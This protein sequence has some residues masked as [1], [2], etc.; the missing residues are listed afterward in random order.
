MTAQ[1]LV[2][3]L[4]AAG[5]AH[6]KVVTWSRPPPTFGHGPSGATAV[7]AVLTIGQVTGTVPYEPVIAMRYVRRHLKAL[8]GCLA[9]ANRPAALGSFDAEIAIDAA[10]KVTSASIT[11][12][13]DAKAKSCALAVLERIA[14]PAAKAGGALRFPFIV[15]RSR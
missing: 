12:M 4:D 1:R 13:P 14:F 9:P 2:D 10:G 6:F 5:R 15:E 7:G 11:K 8:R 3:L